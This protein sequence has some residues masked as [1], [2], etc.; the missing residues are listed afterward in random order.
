MKFAEQVQCKKNVI[1]PLQYLA[2]KGHSEK[3]WNVLANALWQTDQSSTKLLCQT[4]TRHE[5]A[6]LEALNQSH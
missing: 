3:S 2:V 6:F 5:F 1:G 4:D